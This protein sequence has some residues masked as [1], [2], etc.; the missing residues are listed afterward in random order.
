[1]VKAPRWA[2]YLGHG[3]PASLDIFAGGVHF[4]A[5]A[6]GEYRQLANR[7][8]TLVQLGKRC[9][10]LDPGNRKALADIDVGCAMVESDKNNGWHRDFFF[11][12]LLSAGNDQTGAEA[13]PEGM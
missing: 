9:K 6:G 3:V 8:P 7:T 2:R 12:A 4:Q 10:T 1:M 13:V 11:L 5:I